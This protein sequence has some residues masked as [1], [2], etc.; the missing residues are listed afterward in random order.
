MEP[1]D[2]KRRRFPRQ[3]CL[4]GVEGHRCRVILGPSLGD[5][6]APAEDSEALD[7]WVRPANPE[8]A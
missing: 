5:G 8:K 6:P 1:A 7:A 3:Q 2:P 4:H